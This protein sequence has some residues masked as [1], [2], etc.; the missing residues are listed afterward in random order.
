MKSYTC[1]FQNL[2]KGIDCC[3]QTVTSTEI[4]FHKAFSQTQQTFSEVSDATKEIIPHS[5]HFLRL[6]LSKLCVISAKCSDK[7]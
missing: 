2:R 5:M 3:I 7:S 6:A 4:L 1:M